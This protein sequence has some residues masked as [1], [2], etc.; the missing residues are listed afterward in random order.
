MAVI[1]SID[2]ATPVCSVAVHVEGKPIGTQVYRLEKSHASLLPIIVK[3]TLENVG[4]DFTA[5]DALAVSAG[6]G[7]YTGLRIGTSTAKGLA[8]ALG[9]P[10]I[11]VPTLDTMTHAMQAM[12]DENVLLCPMI[13][14]RRMEV[15]TQLV[16][17]D[18]VVWETQALIIEPDTFADFQENT[19]VLFGD[20]AAKTQQVLAQP[21]L[22]WVVGVH[23][24]ADA[25][26]ELAWRKYTQGVFEDVA[27]YE[28][29]YL[30]EFQAKPAKKLL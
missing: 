14:A 12:Y 23:P 4:M 30:K 21:N 1:L 7:S 22:R 5:V 18:R 13:D 16:Q 26:G 27:Y 8:F 25:L 19:I 11:A 2:T 17:G 29:I 9:K 6:P 20:G 24:S 15:Y 3:Q 28:P 10:L